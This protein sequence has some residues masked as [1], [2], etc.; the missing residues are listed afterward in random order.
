MRAIQRGSE[1]PSIQ[2]EQEA[3]S[4]IAAKLTQQTLRPA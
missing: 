3:K 1:K 2:E 4:W